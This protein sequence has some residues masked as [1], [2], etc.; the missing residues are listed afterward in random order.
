MK[1]RCEKLTKKR[2]SEIP[3]LSAKKRQADLL[4][5]TPRICKK[6]REVNHGSRSTPIRMSENASTVLA[7]AETNKN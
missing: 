4:L 2:R 5:I 6:L 7:P 1:G 3:V